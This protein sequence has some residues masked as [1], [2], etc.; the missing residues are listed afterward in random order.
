[1][2]PNNNDDDETKK[3][4]KLSVAR[5]MNE[6]HGKFVAGEELKNLRLD[7]SSLRQNL[8][9]AEALNDVKRIESL[10]KAIKVGESRDPDHMLKKALKIVDQTRKM[11]DASQEE[12]DY[13][14]EKWEKI[15]EHARDHVQEFNLEGLWVGR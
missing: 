10:T 12:K 2:I 9:W 14:I 1:M 15:A 5:A 4:K 8:Q 3:S 13:L 6:S 7:L 11:K